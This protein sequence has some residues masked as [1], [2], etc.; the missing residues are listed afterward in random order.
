MDNEN[1][2]EQQEEIK[3]QLLKEGHVREKFNDRISQCIRSGRRS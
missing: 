3:I 1:L 2:D